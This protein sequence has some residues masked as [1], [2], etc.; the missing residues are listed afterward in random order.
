M[1]KGQKAFVLP[2]INNTMAMIPDPVLE[3]MEKE[4]RDKKEAALE[5]S[6]VSKQNATHKEYKAFAE[7]LGYYGPLHRAHWR[8][9]WRPSA[10]RRVTRPPTGRGRPM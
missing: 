2:H 4:I 3:A 6:T 10:R 9:F 5:R 7:N 8:C 1:I